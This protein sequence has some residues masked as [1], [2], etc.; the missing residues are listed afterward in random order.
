MFNFVIFFSCYLLFSLDLKTKT[1]SFL[2]LR[3]HYLSI[4]S[5]RS[6]D[7]GEIS[8]IISDPWEISQEARFPPLFSALNAWSVSCDTNSGDFV[9]SHSVLIYCLASVGGKRYLWWLQIIYRLGDRSYSGPS[10]FIRS[11]TISLQCST[12]KSALF[13]LYIFH[14]DT[15]LFSECSFRELFR[16]LDNLFSSLENEIKVFKPGQ[17]LSREHN[18]EI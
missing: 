7:Q 11:F 12:V 5:F 18:P 10:H 14:S 15:V 17:H 2:E 3:T 9:W 6:K 4:H 16:H 13:I 8:H 1:V